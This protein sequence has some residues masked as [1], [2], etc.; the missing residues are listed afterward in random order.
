MPSIITRAAGSARG[1]G[2]AATI[3]ASGPTIGAL[4]SWGTNNQGQLGLG[5]LTYY[6][7]PK[8]IGALTTWTSAM[9]PGNNNNALATQSNNTLWTWGNNQFGQLGLGNVTYYSSPKQVGSLTNWY[10]NPESI[11]TTNSSCFAIKTDGTLWAWGQNNSGQLGLN[12]RTRYSSPIQVGSL[13]NWV[14]ISSGSTFTNGIKTDGTLWVWGQNAYGNLGLGN[15]TNYSSPKQV[16]SLTNWSTIFN[17]YW[18]GLALKTNGT[19]WSW[20]QNNNGQLGQG[21]TT[22]ISSPVQIGALTTWLNLGGGLYTGIAISTSNALWVWGKNNYGQ[23]GLGNTTYYSS[24]K[25]VGSLTNWL[26]SGNVS[27]SQSFSHAVKTNNTLWFLG[28]LNNNGQGGISNTTNYIS[29]PIQVGGL[30]TWQSAR[31][32]ANAVMA[33]KT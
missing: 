3:A 25:Q 24:P 12:N 2:W 21:N 28:G 7:S 22:N 30:S 27:G 32:G 18:G 23:L 15:T 11:N 26:K 33:I 14:W 4:W 5:N 19:I 31:D 13:T 16:G 10:T 9:L 8:Q 6:S 17:Q 29:S 1:W 20:G